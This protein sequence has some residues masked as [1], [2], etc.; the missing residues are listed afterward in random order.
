MRWRERRVAACRGCLTMKFVAK[1]VPMVFRT[2]RGSLTRRSFVSRCF[3]V[4]LGRCETSYNGIRGKKREGVGCPVAWTTTSSPQDLSNTNDGWRVD[5]KG[6][7]QPADFVGGR[8][9]GSKPAGKQRNLSWDRP[10]IEAPTTQWAIRP[11]VVGG[12]PGKNISARSLPL[13]LAA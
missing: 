9:A 7:S 8:E 4:N 6:R 1:P 10:G 13:F 5:L 3:G 12:F 2:L 11:R